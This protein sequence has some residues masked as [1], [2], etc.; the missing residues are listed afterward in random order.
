ML[1]ERTLRQFT[2]G[3]SL[4]TIVFGLIPFLFPRF[5]A[6]LFNIP[7]EDEPAAVTTVRAIG[8]RDTISGVGILSATLHEGRVAPWLL[9]RALTDGTDAIGIAIAWLAGSRNLGF[10]L[11]GL[12][13][14][15]ATVV[16]VFLWREHKSARQ[17]K[18][19]NM[20]SNPAE[21]S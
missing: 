10:T 2:I 11:L 16:D 14:A 12:I 6:R 18:I 9:A 21:A 20:T 8:A 19:P 15:G 5:F 1:P 4:G 3:L 17:R 7:L 13:A